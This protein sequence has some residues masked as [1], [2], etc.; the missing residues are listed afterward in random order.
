M[1]NIPAPALADYVSEIKYWND[2]YSTPQ[3][4]MTAEQA[5]EALIRKNRGVFDEMKTETRAAYGTYVWPDSRR[6]SKRHGQRTGALEFGPDYEVIQGDP[7]YPIGYRGTGL[8]QGPWVDGSRIFCTIGGQNVS[9]YISGSARLTAAATD[10]MIQER[11]IELRY[12]LQE[13]NL[14][15]DIP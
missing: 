9:G 1:P 13:L 15:D 2:Y 10:R 6:L 12:R 11:E 4:G 8:K 14:E 5:R 3:P 7:Q